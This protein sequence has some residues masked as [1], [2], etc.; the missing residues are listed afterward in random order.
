MEFCTGRLDLGKQKPPLK[1]KKC[2]K[3]LQ[4]TVIKPSIS[5]PELRKETSG[6]NQEDGVHL[7][8]PCW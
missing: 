6:F 8:H 1:I 2:K 5:F 7:P 3:Y 4:H